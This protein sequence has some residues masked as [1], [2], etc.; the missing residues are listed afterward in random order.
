MRYLVVF[1]WL[2][3]AACGAV[4]TDESRFQEKVEE[5]V[6]RT[7]RDPSS[8]T[9]GKLTL[10]PEQDSA[11][12]NVN[13]KNGFGGYTGDELFAYDGGTVTHFGDGENPRFQKAFDN[14]LK[15]SRERSQKIMDALRPQDR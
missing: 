5:A 1:L 10:N 13:A 15:L 8:A 4:Q 3:L 12:G 2:G 9:F 11:C 6:R 14:C 7:L